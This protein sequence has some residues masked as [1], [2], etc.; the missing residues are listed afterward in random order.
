M[1]RISGLAEQ[2]H[3]PMVAFMRQA[4]LAGG[5]GASH[6]PDGEREGQSPLAC[7]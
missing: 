1:E 6:A 2:R 3:E 4:S 7:A 5:S